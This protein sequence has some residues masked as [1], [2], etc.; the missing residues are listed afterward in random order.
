MST[1]KGPLCKVCGNCYYER[2]LEIDTCQN[3]F[4]ERKVQRR[5]Q[6]DVKVVMAC[7]EWGGEALFAT[8][9]GWLTKEEARKAGVKIYF[10]RMTQGI[11]QTLANPPYGYRVHSHD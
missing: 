1:I 4:A 7:C 8:G 11:R 3:C 5:Q 2:F 6:P 10:Q 9:K